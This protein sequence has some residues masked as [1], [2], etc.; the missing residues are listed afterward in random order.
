MLAFAP[1]DNNTEKTKLVVIVKTRHSGWFV[2]NTE[3]A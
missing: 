3:L 2:N 1:D